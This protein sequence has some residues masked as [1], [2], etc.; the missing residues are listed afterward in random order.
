MSTR[1]EAAVSPGF[2]GVMREAGRP[3]SFYFSM[4]V[5]FAVIAFGGFAP[6]YLVPM[7]THSFEGPA[8]VHL[9]GFLF[10][11]W[12]IL[13][14][15]QT[16]LVGSGRVDLHRGVGLG[17]ISLAT[18][19][20]FTAVALLA[21]RLKVAAAAG[22]DFTAASIVALTQISM[23][24]IFCA[25]AIVNVRRPEIHKRAMFLATVSLLNAAAA[26]IFLFLQAVNSGPSIA[27]ARAEPQRA[28]VAALGG[29]LVVDLLILTAIAY[30]WRT[31]GRPHRMYLIGGGC[32]LAVQLLR[33]PLARSE[34][35]RSLADLLLALA[36]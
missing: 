33:V 6:T 18:A 25:I 11:A 2:D 13:L 5:I 1:N 26:R 19:M 34:L 35:G 36:V 32:V 28:F 24:T 9:H 16:R 14:V 31:R 12:T 29:A 30:D 8:L 7:A 22:N 17:G 15:V 3:G 10:F 23:F 4:S 21:L 27:E 20:I